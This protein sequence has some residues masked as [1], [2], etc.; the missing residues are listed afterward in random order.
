MDTVLVLDALSLA[1]RQDKL[2]FRLK[3][4]D[5][6][7]TNDP[8]YDTSSA[9]WHAPDTNDFRDVRL[10]SL[11]GVKI[12][13]VIATATDVE[14]AQVLRCLK[15]LPGRKKILRVVVHNE[16]Y[17][18]GHFGAYPTALFKSTM[19][20]GGPSGATLGANSALQIW[21]PKAI[22]MVGIAF[23]AD[24]AKH[25]VADVLLAETVQSMTQNESVKK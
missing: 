22:I 21:K 10:R 15:P 4:F 25:G 20:P 3:K 7:A 8:V 9:P 17:Y 16:T 11:A 14:R 24:R 5:E 1:S 13:V 18:V 12:A 2:T 6:F 23:G 19:G